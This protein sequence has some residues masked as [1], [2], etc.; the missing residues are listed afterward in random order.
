MRKMTN[1]ERKEL[2]GLIRTMMTKSMDEDSVRRILSIGTS[3]NGNSTLMD[4]I[5]DDILTSSAWES[6]GH[7]NDDDVRF[8]IG[9]T[10]AIR[11]GAEF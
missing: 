4:H 2:D 3:W 7:Y 5:V 6:D 1:D 11:L 9:R 8:A 10:I